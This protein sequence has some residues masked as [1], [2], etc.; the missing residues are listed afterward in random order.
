MN[1]TL[2]METEA[3]RKWSAG[4][5]RHMDARGAKQT[6]RVLAFEFLNRVI[7]KTPVDLGRAR[8]GWASYLIANGKGVLRTA[9][10]GQKRQRDVE[11]KFLKGRFE[12]DDFAEGVSEGSFEEKFTGSEQFILLINAVK[13]IVLLEFGSSDQAPAGM[14]RITFREMRANKSGQ[15]ALREEFVKAVAAANRARRGARPRWERVGSQAF[16]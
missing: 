9:T 14:M 15:K 1:V 12:K 3:F 16:G 2:D 8:G 6:L 10:K 13:Y 5:I 4:L 11:G 7:A